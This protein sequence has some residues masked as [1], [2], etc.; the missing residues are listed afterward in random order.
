MALILE[1]Q[2]KVI[3]HQDGG[4]K[5]EQRKHKLAFVECWCICKD[6]IYI[7]HVILLITLKDSYVLLL[8]LLLLKQIIKTE[9]LRGKVTR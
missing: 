9:A 3:Q 5:E 2:S 8:L 6:L 7:I 4:K 1:K